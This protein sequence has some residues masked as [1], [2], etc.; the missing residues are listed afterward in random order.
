MFRIFEV[1][2]EYLVFFYFFERNVN[3]SFNDLLF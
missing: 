1:V 3:V 2:L